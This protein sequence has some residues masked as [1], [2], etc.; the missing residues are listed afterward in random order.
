MN[1]LKGMQQSNFE[2]PVLRFAETGVFF[3]EREPADLYPPP[4]HSVCCGIKVNDLRQE[5]RRFLEISPKV[6]TDCLI[7]IEKNFFMC[8]T[9]V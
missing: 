1:N 6:D 5:Y 2:D 3:F 7:G 8:Y 9:V 4:R